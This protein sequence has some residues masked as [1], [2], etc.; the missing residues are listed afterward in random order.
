MRVQLRGEDIFVVTKLAPRFLGYNETLYAIDESLERLNFSYI[1]LYLI[2][3]KEC[4][5]FL[6]TCN[7]GEPRGTWKES[8][9]AMEYATKHGKIRSLGVSNFYAED[10]YELLNWSI[11]P[12]SIIQNWFDPF[13]PDKESRK[14][15][16]NTT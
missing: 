4:D 6:L 1:D 14:S 8:W 11:E 12:V 5:D 16:R 13:N 7:E 9:R 15:V 3:S 10:I 2:H